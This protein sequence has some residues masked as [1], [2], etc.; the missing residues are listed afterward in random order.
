M[1]KY[2][3]NENGSET[4]YKPYVHFLSTCLLV[5][6]SSK[7]PS[8]KLEHERECVKVKTLSPTHLQLTATTT[9]SVFCALHH[10]MWLA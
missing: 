3:L 1:I 6:Q 8:A 9:K 2:D 7:S 10:F 5:H 4:R